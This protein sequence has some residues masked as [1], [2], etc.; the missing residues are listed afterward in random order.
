MGDGDAVAIGGNHFIHAAR[1]TG[2]AVTHYRYHLESGIGQLYSRGKGERPPV[3]GVQRVEVNVYGKATGT[4]DTG[5]EDDIVFAV[6]FTVDNP[7]Q[8][9]HENANAAAGTPDVREPLAGA[10][11]FMD[12]VRWF[13]HG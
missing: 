10:E 2:I 4:A 5:Y 13:P 11:I 9:L 6:P 1:R 7:N 8:G 3:C 12:E